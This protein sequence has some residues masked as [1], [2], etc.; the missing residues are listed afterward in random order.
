MPDGE[1][2]ETKPLFKGRVVELSVDTVRLPNGQVCD[3]EMIHHP[4]AAAVVPVDDEQRV[5]LI[6]QYR[7]ATGGFVLEVPAGKLDG[8]EPPETCARREVLEE[9]GYRPGRLEAMGWIWTTPG[10]TN[11]RIWLFLATGLVQDRQDLQADEVL[12]VE[13]LPLEEAVERAARGEITDAKSVCALFRAS[14]FLK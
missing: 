2:L 8:G 9:T 14:C 12:T 7:Y 1:R 5:V 11:E 10:F 6:R 3:L 4:G 13:R